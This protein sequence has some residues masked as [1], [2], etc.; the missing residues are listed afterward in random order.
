MHGAAQNGGLMRLCEPVQVAQFSAELERYQPAIQIYEDIAR[1]SMDNNLLKYSAKGYLLNAGICR[2]CG[3]PLPLSCGCPCA[4]MWTVPG[5]G[6]AAYL[7]MCHTCAAQWATA[8]RCRLR[9]SASRT[10][11]THLQ[12]R[13]RAS[14]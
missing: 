5:E 3:A 6:A 10:S 11:T 13:G 8:W 9:W 7:Q 2:L 14:C 4:G 12:A 1:T